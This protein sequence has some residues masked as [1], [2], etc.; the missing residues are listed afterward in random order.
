MKQ[1]EEVIVNINYYRMALKHKCI[2]QLI[3]NTSNMIKWGS[4]KDIFVHQNV[5]LSQVVRSS[6]E[7]CGNVLIFNDILPP[8]IEEIKSLDF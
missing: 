1:T 8:V 6:K 2:T 3:F 7:K 5:F 4:L